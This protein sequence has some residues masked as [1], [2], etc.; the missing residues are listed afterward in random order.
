MDYAII[1]L[2]GAQYLVSPNDVLS[3]SNL[4][5]DEGK[6]F[7]VAEVLLWKENG[8]LEIGT[9]T[10]GKKLNA[11]VLK[12]YKGEKLD[13]FKFTA[14]SRYRRKMGFRPFLSDVQIMGETETS[15]PE[16]KTAVTKKPVITKTGVKP[17]KVVT[18]K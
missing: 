5:I 8:K 2:S 15:V 13:V 4:N 1:K 6:T 11:K 7:D 3:V 14:K 18:K 17:A 9:P 10:V 12:N 16:P